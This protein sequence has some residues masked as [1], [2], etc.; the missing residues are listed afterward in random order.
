MEHKSDKNRAK[1]LENQFCTFTLGILFTSWQDSQ[2]HMLSLDGHSKRALEKKK[3][4][5]KTG[6]Q[7]KPCRKS[8][9]KTEQRSK[10][11]FLSMI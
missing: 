7:L 1:F 5:D 4:V 6:W 8:P 3:S 2:K 10:F 11:F 9:M